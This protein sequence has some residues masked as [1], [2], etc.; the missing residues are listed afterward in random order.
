MRNMLFSWA[1]RQKSAGSEAVSMLRSALIIGGRR[2]LAE[3]IEDI[4]NIGRGK[5]KE[6]LRRVGLEGEA[7]SPGQNTAE[8]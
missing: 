7:S 3:E 1:R 8:D 4:V 5:Y 6:S 2:D